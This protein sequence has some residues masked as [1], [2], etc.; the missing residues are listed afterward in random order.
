M[1]YSASGTQAFAL[2]VAMIALPGIAA[3]SPRRDADDCIDTADTTWTAAVPAPG[4][5]WIASAHSFATGGPGTAYAGT[6]VCLNQY[7][8]SRF[9]IASFSQQYE[10]MNLRLHWMDFKHLDVAYGPTRKPGDSVQVLFQAVLAFG[11][12][13]ITLRNLP[14]DSFPA[15]Q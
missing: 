5:A 13:H 9:V 3:C 2:T 15:I 11:E 12:V 8:Q 4:G 10:R 1:P 7:Q 14:P 6:V